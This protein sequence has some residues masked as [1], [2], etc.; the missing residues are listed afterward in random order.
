MTHPESGCLFTVFL[1]KMELRNVGFLWRE[2]NW[3]PWRKTLGV[4]MRTNNKLNRH[5]VPIA[6]IEPRPHWVTVGDKCSDTTVPFPK[7]KA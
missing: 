1:V 4:G 5:V 6:G 2:N 7:L 3:R